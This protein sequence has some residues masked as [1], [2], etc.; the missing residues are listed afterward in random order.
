MNNN[1]SIRFEVHPSVV[2][3]LGESLITDSVQ[4]LI[5]LV[6][7]SYDADA[8]YV[9][10][11]ISTEEDLIVPG[12]FFG[13]K[14]GRIVVEDDGVGMGLDDVENGWL[15]ISNRR[16]KD[17]KDANNLTIKERTPLGDKGLG[18]LGVQKLGNELEIFTKS[19]NEEGIHFGFSWPDFAST[20]RLQDVPIYLDSWHGNEKC[21]SHLVISDLRD[22]EEWRNKKSIQRLQQEL[23]K[24]LSPF[25]KIRNFSVFVEV[26]GK[27]IDLEQITNKIR[28]AAPLKYEFSFDGISLSIKGKAR[29][30]FFIPNKNEDYEIF[31]RI[32][33][34]DDGQAFFEFLIQKKQRESNC[35]K[36]L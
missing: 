7:N 19:E 36:A 34:R 11:T 35:L 30:N 14:K 15:T 26:N 6:K 22:I 23:S 18:R 25:Q 3:Q 17:F 28:E 27:K 16:K 10:I 21:G 12:S 32:I 2:Y 13:G 31:S 1:K 9:K 5:E 4:A 24:M 20:N 29:L 8:T 33:E